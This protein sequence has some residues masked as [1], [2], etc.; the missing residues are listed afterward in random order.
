MYAYCNNN[1]VMYSDPS[2][3]LLKT[4]DECVT[5]GVSSI[6]VDEWVLLYVGAYSS[7]DNIPKII[8]GVAFGLSIAGV[9]ALLPIPGSKILGGVI[10]GASVI[11]AGLCFIPGIGGSEI[12]RV[13]LFFFNE[14]R[15]E[16][17]IVDLFLDLEGMDKVIT[18]AE[19]YYYVSSKKHPG[20]GFASAPFQIE[21]YYLWAS[22]TAT[23]N[24][25]CEINDYLKTQL[26]W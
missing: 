10:A 1:P 23:S 16:F 9:I 8:S 20:T 14:Y 25:I 11:V 2:G 6:S 12:N 24:E 18:R 19:I 7:N 5:D 13:S 21:G 3:Y 4:F 15:E 26:F 17:I 22:H